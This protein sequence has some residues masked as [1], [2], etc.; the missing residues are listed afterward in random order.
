ME[1]APSNHTVKAAASRA[2][3]SKPGY[4]SPFWLSNWA[5]YSSAA[6]VSLVLF[7]LVWSILAEESESSETGW[8]PAFLFSI[9]FFAFAAA[10]HGVLLRRLRNKYL[11]RREELKFPARSNLALENSKFTLEKHT[12]AINKIQHKSEAA[13]AV[14]PPFP[15]GH[16]E[17]YRACGDYLDLIESVLPTVHAGSPRLAAFRSGQERVRGLQK[18]HLLAWAEEESRQLLR[19]AQIR[20]TTNEKVEIGQRALEVLD[21]AM[22]IYPGERQLTE[23][24]VAV[25]EFIAASYVAH[26]V[27]LAERAAFKENYEQAIDHYRDAL[28][29]LSRE[30]VNPAQREATGGRIEAE[31]S[32][33]ASLSDQSAKSGKSLSAV[34]SDKKSLE[35]ES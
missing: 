26:W 1:R 2:P 34:E 21:T 31:I 20:V 28:F 11:L 13:D 22:Q 6:A 14:N 18:H 23:S 30:S 5:Y 19:E 17:V 7:L 15:E 33:L 32:R 29:Y 12:A 9:V 25:Q 27:E 16:L 24:V 10:L 8:F 3:G 35:A 4:V